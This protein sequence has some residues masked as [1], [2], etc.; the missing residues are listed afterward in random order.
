[1]TVSPA[2]LTRLPYAVELE[3]TGCLPPDMTVFLGKVV[4][5]FE[6]ARKEFGA[7]VAILLR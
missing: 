4:T 1:M 7:E 3:N 6:D 5:A 2:A